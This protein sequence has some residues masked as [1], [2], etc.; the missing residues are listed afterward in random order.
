MKKSN[1]LIS[2]FSLFSSFSTLICCA[3]PSLFVVLGMGAT[4]AS[5]VTY[6]PQL[7]WLSEN[8]I[9][10]F[11]ISGILISFNIFTLIFQK[12]LSCPTDP[13]LAKACMQS[14]KWS[15]IITIISATLWL[16]GFFFAFLSV[17]FLN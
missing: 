13:I 6:F 7:I 11:L 2:Y 12:D 16:I 8:K 3:L 15:M 9:L 1:F 17:Y 14:K 4:V 10:V 5:A